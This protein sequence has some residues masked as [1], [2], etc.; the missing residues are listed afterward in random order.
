MR[1]TDLR[2]EPDRARSAWTRFWTTCAR[3]ASIIFRGWSVPHAQSRTVER[4]P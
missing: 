3:A 2:T 4:N 1:K